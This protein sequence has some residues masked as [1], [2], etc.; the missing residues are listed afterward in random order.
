VFA[1]ILA[2]GSL[3]LLV[4]TREALAYAHCR[5][6]KHPCVDLANYFARTDSK[7]NADFYINFVSQ[8]SA[9]DVLRAHELTDLPLEMLLQG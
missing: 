9:N 2:V 7:G 1:T 8:K 6:R 3:L 4:G 5:N